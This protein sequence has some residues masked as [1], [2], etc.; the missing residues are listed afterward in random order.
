MDGIIN[1]YKEK[2][3]TSHDVV[4][5]L[6]GILHMKKIGHTGTLDPEAEG[7]LPV[8]LGSAT[9]LCDMLTDKVKEYRTV[10]RFG[11][12]T[13]T[14]DMTGEI[15]NE[16]PVTV[17]EQELREVLPKFLGEQEQIPPMY[18]AIKV[19]GK[20]LYELAR[21]GKVIERKGRPVVIHEILLHTVV[22]DVTGRL[23]EAELTV[24][25]GKGT[26]IRSLCRDIGEALGTCAC[27]KSLLRTRSGNCYLTDSLKLSEV[28]ALRDA[29]TL[30]QHIVTVEDVFAECKAFQMKPEWDKLLLNG[31]PVM[32]GNCELLE[33]GKTQNNDF[34]C[35]ETIVECQKNKET[36][37]ADKKSIGI[38]EFPES[39]YRAYDSTGRFLGL[40]E[41]N[42]KK[43]TP[44]KMFL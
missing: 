40:Y 42:G 12:A 1:I 2:G 9:R 32:A 4:A 6:R 14:E 30:E 10:V 34:S 20:K 25:C 3:F 27:M 26:Y 39:W 43:Y 18:S 21:E 19:E 11:I 33:A 44:V 15:I 29:G 16:L 22:L 24:V 13:D 17:G 31:N 5:K 23:Y 37:Q 35:Q 28:E 38:S 41:K 7:V 36:L 8:C